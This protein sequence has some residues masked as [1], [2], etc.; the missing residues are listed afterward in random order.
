MNSVLA[1]QVVAMFIA[2]AFTESDVAKAKRQG[3]KA[4]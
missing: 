4:E 3:V 2:L 1:V